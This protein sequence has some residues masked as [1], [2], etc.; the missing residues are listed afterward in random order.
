MVTKAS[1]IA[2]TCLIIAMTFREPFL[3]LKRLVVFSRAAKVYDQRFHDGVNII[4][5]RNSTGKSTILDFIFFAL[6]GE[7]P[8]W[9]PEAERCDLVLAE[10]EIN[11]TVVTLRRTVNGLRMQPMDIFWGPVDDGL[12]RPF[13]EWQ[14]FPFR[15]SDSKESFSQILFR[16]AKIPEARGQNEINI[17]MHQLLRLMCVDQLS[18]V[19]SLFRD[20]QFDSPLTRKTVGELMYGLH[21]NKRY[22]D[23]LLV[24]ARRKSLENCQAEF[25]TLK[26]VLSDSGQMF[27]PD[28]VDSAISEK[29]AQL[30]RIREAI[31]NASTTYEIG[32]APEQMAEFQNAE[33]ALRNAKCDFATIA[34][35]HATLELDME[36]SRE[37]IA[38]LGRRISALDESVAAEKSL[39]RLALSI[40]PECLKPLKESDDECHCFLCKEPVGESGR[41][42]RMAKLKNELIAQVQESNR[43]LAEKEKAFSKMSS[44]LHSARTEIEA[45]ERRFEDLIQRVKSRRDAAI[46]DLLI[47][48]GTVETELKSLETQSRVVQLL[49][50]SEQRTK[51]LRQ[52]IS[53]IESRIANSQARQD[54]RRYDAEAA[55][56]KLAVELLHSDLEREEYFMVALQVG[57]DFERNL[58]SVDNRVGFSASSITFLKAA[59]HF[60]IFFA[61]LELPFFRY[62][63]FLTNDNIE[64][65]GMEPARSKNLQKLIVKFSKR[66]TV[67]HQ[68]IITTSMIDDEL[69]TDE[70]CIGPFYTLEHKTLEFPAPNEAST[71]PPAA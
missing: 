25:S 34:Q 17:T 32:A 60:A 36:D 13:T 12:S 47:S 68:I 14:Q 22:E 40:C 43:I 26:A 1:V 23:E 46:D 49:R 35:Q 58:V 5:G 21:D 50:D 7:L 70:F 33:R 48:R 24:R 59:A 38:N 9:K 20:E 3:M 31:S 65:K 30:E 67:R 18:S 54:G 62:P 51:Q 16:A 66:A 44:D 56:N 2:Q 41:T 8:S 37:F 4:R 45:A 15:R 42:K 61:S 57:V 10:V 71:P 52:E 28:A 27:D 29:E 19:L 11:E 53:D 55:V 6:G 63:K 69:N 64:D 39:G